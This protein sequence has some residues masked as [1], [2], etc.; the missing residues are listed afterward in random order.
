MFYFRPY[1]CN[2][3]ND[4]QYL[5]VIWKVNVSCFAIE[6]LQCLLILVTFPSGYVYLYHGMKHL[7][8]SYMAQNFKICQLLAKY[9]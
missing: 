2:H 7:C 8:I 1:E 3:K 9:S 5:T 4:L 6:Y